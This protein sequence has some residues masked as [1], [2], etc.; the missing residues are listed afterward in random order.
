MTKRK[1][2][3]PKPLTKLPESLVL[4]AFA[5]NYD[6]GKGSMN[7]CLE[8]SRIADALTV[9]TYIYKGTRTAYVSGYCFPLEYEARKQLYDMLG[10]TL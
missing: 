2:P 10:E 4:H 6:K 9:K 8:F 1:M 5:D 3:Y 7:V